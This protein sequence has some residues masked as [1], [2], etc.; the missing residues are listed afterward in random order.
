MVHRIRFVSAV[1]QVW[2]MA[3]DFLCAKGEAKEEKPKKKKKKKDV[4]AIGLKVEIL[5]H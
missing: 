5:V 2:Y 3:Q 4:A 1:A